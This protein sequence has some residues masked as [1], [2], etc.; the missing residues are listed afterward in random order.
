MFEGAVELS[1]ILAASSDVNNCLAR[2]WFRFGMS[3]PESDD[4]RCSLNTIQ[5]AFSQSHSMRDLIITITS[6]TAFRSARW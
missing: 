1:T 6:S 5:S 2:Q 3:R 4:D